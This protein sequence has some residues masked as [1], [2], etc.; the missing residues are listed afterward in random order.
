M[1]P[2]PVRR[3]T[4]AVVTLLTAT[5]ALSATA[6]AD[7]STGS[8]AGHLTDAGDPV[9]GTTVALY[10]LDFNAVSS[11]TTDEAG[12]FSFADVPAG[13]YKV[14]FELP[15]FLIQFV[16]HRLSF[17]VADP[18]TVVAG[19]ETTVEET[20]LPHGSLSG[21]VTNSDAT[22]F[23]APYVVARSDDG[24]VFAQTNGD[25]DGNYSLPFLPVGTYRVSFQHDFN[26]PV[27][28]AHGKTSLETADPIDI[29]AGTATTL[30]ETFLPTGAVAGHLSRSGAPVSGAEVRLE[31]STGTVGFA[32]TGPDGEFRI[33]A[34]PGSY[35]LQ[36]QINGIVEYFHQK[37]DFASA[38][39]VTVAAGPDTIVDEEAFPVGT[40]TGHLTGA[41]G[42]PVAG[43]SVSVEDGN[44]FL[45][46]FTDSE[47]AFSVEAPAGAYRVAFGLES[48][49]R[50]WA[51]GRSSAGTADTITVVADQA[52]VVDDTLRPAGSVTVTAR[53]AIT[54]EPVAAFCSSVS[55]V[56]A[57]VCTT[58]GTATFPT[59]LAGRYFVD[60]FSDDPRYLYSFVKGVIVTSGE[61]TS[62]V[63]DLQRAATIQ[64]TVRDAA[65]GAPVADVC[66][67]AIP[68]QSPSR[69]G[70]NFG[71][72]SDE[73]G[74]VTMTVHGG[75]YN[76]FAWA[77]DGVHGHQWV[78]LTGGTGA[79]ATSR[80][81]SVSPGATVT[82]PAVRMDEAGTVSGVITDA[83]TGAGLP[84]A[85]AGIASYSDGFGGSE[86][87]A[88]ADET[89][90][91]TFAGL[92]P[93]PWTFFFREFGH[94]AQFSGGTT[95]RFL[96]SG[97]KVK[98]G[99]TTTYNVALGKGTSLSVTVL[100]PQGQPIDF[101]RITAVNALSGD[102]MG[103]GDCVGSQPCVI[104]VLGPQLVKLSYV[105]DVHGEQY[106][107]FRG[108]ADFAHGDV[109]LVPSSGTK[110]VTVTMTQLDP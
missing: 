58:D 101:A 54:H 27:Q 3:L 90:H 22:A 87:Q 13:D 60:A 21:R 36:F 108:G 18:I 96:A 10:D 11:T 89:G 98:V 40:I 1:S 81:V 94:A 73:T 95:S 100:G 70:A 59:V 12:A 26:G 106:V 66:L 109:V 41:D 92:G 107:G 78:G 33:V 5:V 88:F 30:D 20:L 23:T 14:G 38:D 51:F 80:L 47:G 6:F 76:L 8:L 82:V 32:V 85:A 110:Q 29:T 53:D 42:N 79:Q 77:R 37:H 61:N 71:W 69:L 9:A 97:V 65:T 67:D 15:G 24:L 91:Y 52:T 64:T 56:F 72:C 50:Q 16:H 48:M 93:Y 7:P 86:A 75:T 84:F 63:I 39:L 62:V 35:R 49:G 45:S 57:S 43:A 46:G 34:F 104:P 99:Q 55:G 68:P 17:D 44:L 103:S 31:G 28:Y 19:Q 83:T 2:S 105:G 25:A 102:L 4:L 74:A